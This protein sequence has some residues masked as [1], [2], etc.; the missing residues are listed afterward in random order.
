MSAESSSRIPSADQVGHRIDGVNSHVCGNSATGASVQPFTQVT[1]QPPKHIGLRPHSLPPSQ[2]A[3]P[4][5]AL[6]SCRLIA[7][8]SGRVGVIFARDA[9]GKRQTQKLVASI[10]EAQKLVKEWRANRA[11]RAGVLA[12]VAWLANFLPHTPRP[13]NHGPHSKSGI[14]ARPGTRKAGGAR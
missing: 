12:F 11:A 10:D 9:D 2:V 3:Q 8:P 6:D 5:R 1:V 4:P 14:R 13:S 7:H